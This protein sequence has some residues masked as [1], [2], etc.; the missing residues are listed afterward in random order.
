MS[1][2]W[3]ALDTYI[4]VHIMYFQKSPNSLSDFQHCNISSMAGILPKRHSME[5][6]DGSDPELSDVF[7]GPITKE[8]IR[9]HMKT[10]KKNVSVTK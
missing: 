8:E 1:L 10:K 5:S 2:Y 6:D 7:I 4:C 3:G 9:A